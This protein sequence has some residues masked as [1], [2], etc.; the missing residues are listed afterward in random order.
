[1]SRASIAAETPDQASPAKKPFL[2]YFVLF[3]VSMAAM[4]ALLHVLVIDDPLIANAMMLAPMVFIVL[5]GRNAIANARRSGGPADAQANYLKR[6]LAV[7]LLYVGSLFA[8][9]ALIDEGDPVTVLSVL[10]AFLPGLAVA[11]YFWA[12]GRLI[13]EIKDEFLRMLQ[14]RQALIATG[15]ALSAASIYGFLENFGQVPHLDAFW[16]PIVWFG[17]LGIGAVA[18]KMAYGTVGADC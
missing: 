9:K 8:A 16:W 5:A 11:G 2:I 10:L 15:F 13:V 18:N 4:A 3:V 12:I 14:V 6:M 17:G 1:M 7:S